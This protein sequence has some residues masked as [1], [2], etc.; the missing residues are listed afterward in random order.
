MEKETPYAIV[1]TTRNGIGIIPYDSSAAAAPKCQNA[2][3]TFRCCQTDTRKPPPKKGN[4]FRI[5]QQTDYHI[6]QYILLNF[7]KNLLK[8]FTN[9][10]LFVLS[11]HRLRLENRSAAEATRT[12][13]AI[14]VKYGT[15]DQKH[16][17]CL[18]DAEEQPHQQTVGHDDL[19]LVPQSS[20]IE[21]VEHRLGKRSRKSGLFLFFQTIRSQAQ[22]PLTIN[23]G[24]QGSRGFR[25]AE[26]A[27]S[28]R[29]NI[30]RLRLG[31]RKPPFAASRIGQRPCLEFA[32]RHAVHQA[33]W[34]LDPHAVRT[35]VRTL[36]GLLHA[37]TGRS[38]TQQ[39]EQRGYDSGIHILSSIGH[40]S[41]RIHRQ[42]YA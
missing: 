31:G 30:F 15:N 4:I 1:T 17:G 18:A 5:M 27:P 7:L 23:P 40:V 41:C 28:L 39:S 12:R 34:P 16:R 42:I 32:H 37:R 13:I 6:Q 21:Q 26:R 11:L 8:I 33:D 10:P 2:G 24:S 25:I 22:A 20:G 9:L 38:E 19:R 3:S 35:A 29:R 14:Q 36:R